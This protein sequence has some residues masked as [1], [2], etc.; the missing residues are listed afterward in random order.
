MTIHVVKPNRLS[1][2]GSFSREYSP[3][4]TIQ[5][6]D[7]VRF[8]TLDSGWGIGPYTSFWEREK[9]PRRQEGDGGHA[10]CGPI[11]LH[12]AKAGMTLEVRINDI[13]TGSW[14]WS[15]AGGFS[16]DINNW[17][18][19]ADGEQFI[20]NW[21]LDTKAMTGVSHLG[22]KVGLRPFM[23]V[24]GVAP[25]EPGFHSTW[26]PHFWGGN[27]DCKELIA[28]STLFLPISVTG[29]LFSVGDGHAVQGDGEVGVPALECPMEL[30]DVTFFVRDDIKITYPRAKTPNGWIT[31]GFHESVNEA[32][33]IALKGMLDLME[34]LYGYNRKEALALASLVVD[35]RITQIANKILGVHAI[36]PYGAIR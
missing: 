2:R 1:I 21:E 16:H 18:G 32:M 29:A 36:L 13:V 15:S 28:G 27:I 4:M 25:D 8:S 12:G 19:L 30:V 22:H 11:A 14:G 24:M 3:I 35:L 9:F 5:S 34:E 17:L 20:L 33:M 26:Q 10:L 7:T 31:F 6:G 23:G